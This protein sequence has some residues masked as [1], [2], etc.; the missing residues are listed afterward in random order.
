MW[1]L[2][3]LGW[4]STKQRIKS[5]AQGHNP[6]LPVRLEP[7]TPPSSCAFIFHKVRIKIIKN[8]VDPVL[9]SWL[10]QKP[11]NLAGSLLYINDGIDS[12]N[13]SA[14]AV[15]CLLY[16]IDYFEVSCKEDQITKAQR[17]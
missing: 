3:F 11:V 15:N 7:A 1:G 17:E 16:I 4:T 14:L 6:V 10:P 12:R 13:R 5:L 2:V 9:I 8:N